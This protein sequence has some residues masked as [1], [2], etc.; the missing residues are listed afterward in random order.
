MLKNKFFGFILY[1][2]AYGNGC[3][4]GFSPPF[5]YPRKTALSKK[6]PTAARFRVLPRRAAQIVNTMDPLAYHIVALK[7][8]FV[9]RLLPLFLR[10]WQL[11][12]DVFALYIVFNKKT[13]YNLIA[14][15]F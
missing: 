5:P 2:A 7:R 10:F 14:K 1:N 6:S 15:L 13:C 9:N 4:G 12:D 8:G 3:C 11:K